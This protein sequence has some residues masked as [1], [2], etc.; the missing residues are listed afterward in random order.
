MVQF[1]L[2][3][4]NNLPL[5]FKN[6]LNSTMTF[7]ARHDLSCGRLSD[8]VPAL[9]SFTQLKYITKKARQVLPSQG[10]CTCCSLLLQC[11]PLAFYIIASSHHLDY[12]PNVSSSFSKYPFWSSHPSPEIPRN[13]LH[14]LIRNWTYFVYLF[15][16]CPSFPCPHTLLE[17]KSFG[18]RDIISLVHCCILSIWNNSWY[19]VDVSF[20][21]DVLGNGVY[22][23]CC[24]LFAYWFR[25]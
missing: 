21:S 15:D 22:F 2:K 7:E 8:I 24:C 12:S 23:C 6:N 16:Y 9:S 13:C 3:L 18:S 17:F 14:M 25:T 5:Y 20:C 1:S 19:I 10:P 4:I 11:F